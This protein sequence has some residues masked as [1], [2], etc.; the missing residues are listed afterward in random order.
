MRYYN[1]V[2]IEAWYAPKLPF[3]FGPKGYNGLPGLILEIKQN[4]KH[5]V[6]A[7]KINWDEETFV[8]KPATG[9]RIT[10]KEL[11]AKFQKAIGEM[12]MMKN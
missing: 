8:I 6:R 9:K 2:K 5:Y 3:K 11:D 12:K 10:K 1:P 4:D 7:I